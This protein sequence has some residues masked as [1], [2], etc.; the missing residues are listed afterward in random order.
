MYSTT[1]HYQ[2]LLCCESFRSKV[3]PYYALFGTHRLLNNTQMENISLAGGKLYFPM[4]LWIIQQHCGL[5]SLLNLITLCPMDGG[6]SLY[7]CRY[8]CYLNT[9][10]VFCFLFFFLVKNEIQYRW[11]DCWGEENE[12]WTKMN[13]Y[14]KINTELHNW[15]W[16]TQR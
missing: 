4:V 6:Q 11:W 3:E 7:R 1:H 13:T 14:T 16:G 9:Q 10:P 2:Y 12:K 8:I 15:Q 5:G